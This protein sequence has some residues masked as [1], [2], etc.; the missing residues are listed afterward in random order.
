M[1][2][3]LLLLNSSTFVITGP[4]TTTLSVG[5]M[6]AGQ[7]NL[8]AGKEVGDVTQ[9]LTDTFSITNQNTVPVI[10]GTNSG[11]HGE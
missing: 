4:A 8:A 1:I 6:I 2:I 5:K 11:F 7:T 3:I 10:C 9:C